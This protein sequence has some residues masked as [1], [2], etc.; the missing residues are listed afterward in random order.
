MSKK[1]SFMIRTMNENIVFRMTKPLSVNVSN[2][3]LEKVNSRI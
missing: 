3:C 1:F 2:L